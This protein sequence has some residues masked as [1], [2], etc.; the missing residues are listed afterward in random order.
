MS[1]Y[2]IHFSERDVGY[3][4]A[5]GAPTS[6]K[7]EVDF[8]TVIVDKPWG[9]ESLLCRNPFADVWNL[10]IRSGEITSMHCHPHKRTGLVVLEGE[11][12]FTTLNT[13]IH[14]RPA[15]GVCIDAGVFHSTRALSP[16]GAR[17]LEVESPP[18]KYDL[19][20]LRDAYGRAGTQYES[21]EMMR[22]GDDGC[23]RFKDPTPLGFEERQLGGG[24]LCLCRR[25]ERYAPGDSERLRD[26][27]VV[28]VLEGTIYSKRGQVLHGIAD[29]VS[30]SEYV[31]D[32][33]SHVLG[34]LTLLLISTSA[35][36][37]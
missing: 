17:V 6:L 5:Q 11:A 7:E 22:V 14:L 20:R 9:Y 37:E 23:P 34:D 30:R 10:Y 12:L 32:L 27:E 25:R 33:T 3:L 35:A 26:F 31:N 8:S 36:A 16:G 4:A 24:R 29:I 28:V 13:S 15:D 18:L 19:V 21:P 2:R 1:I